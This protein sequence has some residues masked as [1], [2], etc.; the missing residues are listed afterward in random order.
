M[1][2][3]AAIAVG[4]AIFVAVIA[5]PGSPVERLAAFHR[6]WWIMAAITALAFVPAYV[7]IRPSREA[8]RQA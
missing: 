2:R 4:V 5:A 3:Q 1:I 6:G 8:R 7:L